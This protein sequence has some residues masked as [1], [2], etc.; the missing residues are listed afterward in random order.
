[1]IFPEIDYDKVERIHG[2]DITIVTNAGKNDVAK[3][4]LREMGMPFAGEQPG[5]RAFERRRP[6]Q[7]IAKSRPYAVVL[8]RVRIGNGCDVVCGHRARWIVQQRFVEA[9]FRRTGLRHRRELRTK[10]KAAQ[11]VV[12][13][14]K[15]P[16]GVHVEQSVAA[17]GPEVGHCAPARSRTR[18]IQKFRRRPCQY[19]CTW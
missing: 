7:A 6:Q 5:I 8:L 18:R 4:L 16:G 3:A 17:C 10:Q 2:M 11:K 13:D 1:M 14:A 12:R 19:Q 15:P 9:K